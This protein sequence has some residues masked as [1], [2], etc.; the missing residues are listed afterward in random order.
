MPF[1]T[2][3]HGLVSKNQK[4]FSKIGPWILPKRAVNWL[5]SLYNKCSHT[6]NNNFY[7]L[8]VFVI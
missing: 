2:T 6:L 1:W 4:C 3:D 7:I 8:N 5:Y